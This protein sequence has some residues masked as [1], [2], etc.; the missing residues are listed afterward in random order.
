MT[1]ENNLLSIAQAVIEPAR[2]YGYTGVFTTIW[3]GE[4]CDAHVHN[5]RPQIKWLPTFALILVKDRG[6]T[7]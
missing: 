2:R 4:L 7:L 6:P 5:N 1:S 3:M